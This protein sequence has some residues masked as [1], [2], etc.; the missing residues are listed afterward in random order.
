MVTLKTRKS[1]RNKGIL[2]VEAALIFPVLLMVIFG[3]IYYSWL[4]MRAHQITNAARQGARAAI[5]HG[6]TMANEDSVARNA[7]NGVM[8]SAWVGLSTSDYVM[9]PP[10]IT[11][12]IDP[13]HYNV[14]IRLTVSTAN[15]KIGLGLGSVLGN[16]PRP[17][18]LLTPPTLQASA[19]MA[20]EGP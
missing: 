18:N 16:M 15:P 9:D 8:S 10:I 19:T 2:T 7:V 1:G 5:C 14:T 11:S 12:G 17:F 20:K 6:V 13:S 4:F 3:A